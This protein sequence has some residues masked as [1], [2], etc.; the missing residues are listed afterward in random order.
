MTSQVVDTTSDLIAKLETLPPEKLQQVLDF[1]E[2][3]AQKYT[4]TPESEQTPQKRV[5]GLNQGEIWMSDDFNEPLPDEF[6]L[7]EGEI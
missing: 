3:L 2:F 6:W 1:V 5:L 7:G 4:Q